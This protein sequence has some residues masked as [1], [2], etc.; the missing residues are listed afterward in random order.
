MKD[1]INWSLPAND[2]VETAQDLK[3][4]TSLSMSDEN[5]KILTFMLI[6]GRPK[7]L[8]GRVPKENHALV[9]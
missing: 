2:K 3:F 7:Y 8:I 1:L 4:L 6:N 5:S 9:T